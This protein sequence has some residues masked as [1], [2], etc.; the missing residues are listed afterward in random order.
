[1]KMVTT[2]AAAKVAAMATGLAMATSMLSFAPI[3]H[4]ATTCTFSTDL[5]IGATGM[6]VTCL[7]TEL[8]AGG[9]KFQ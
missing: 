5:T 2:K 1:M 3:A 6:S 4:A 9:F 8:I 7:Q